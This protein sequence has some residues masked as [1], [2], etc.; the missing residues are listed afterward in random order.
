MFQAPVN[1][2]D[3]C[4][5]DPNSILSVFLQ[6][7][8]NHLMDQD[9]EVPTTS[10]PKALMDVVAAQPASFWTET[11]PNNEFQFNFSYVF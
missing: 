5:A 10:I 1:A 8:R 4:T 6:H 11:N 2:D 9:H 7:Q 3:Q